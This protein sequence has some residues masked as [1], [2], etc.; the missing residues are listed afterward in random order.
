MKFKSNIMITQKSFS[1]A[2]NFEIKQWTN[3]Q[4][5]KINMKRANKSIRRIIHTGK[6]KSPSISHIIR[7]VYCFVFK[8][9][10]DYLT[11]KFINGDKKLKVTPL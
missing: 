7:G 1:V 9:F 3:A 8:T 2:L 4:S 11:Q 6:S 5:Q 10:S